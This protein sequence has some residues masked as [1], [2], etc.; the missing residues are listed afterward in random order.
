MG[1]LIC[2]TISSRDPVALLSEHSL[3]KCSPN[4][5]HYNQQLMGTRAL[6]GLPLGTD[7]SGWQGPS[8]IQRKTN[9]ILFPIVPGA[10]RILR[11]SPV[12]CTLEYSSMPGFSLGRLQSMNGSR[13]FKW[14]SLKS[15]RT[16]TSS[17]KER[18]V[19]PCH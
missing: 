13:V 12:G 8:Q 11:P 17:L 3:A 15:N 6:M 18:R 16:N 2:L 14:T 9:T 10:Q 4:R 7:G 5:K 19:M 1:I